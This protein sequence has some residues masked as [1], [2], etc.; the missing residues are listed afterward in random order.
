VDVV[1]RFGKQI[2]GA[3]AQV[4]NERL[5]RGRSQRQVE[6]DAVVATLIFDVDRYGVVVAAALE[7]QVSERR[8]PTRRHEL[9]QL[10]TVFGRQRV[11]IEGAT[12]PNGH[13]AAA[14][15]EAYLHRPL[16]RVASRA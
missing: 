7:P 13:E 12:A 2:A 9:T 11:G 6:D 10:R 5:R 8:D 1:S 3:S 4:T 15:G 16:P 14:L